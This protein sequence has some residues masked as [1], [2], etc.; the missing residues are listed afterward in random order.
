MAGAKGNETLSNY[1]KDF[2]SVL[3]GY[4]ERI[5]RETAMIKGLAPGE[6]IAQRDNMLLE[7]GED[8]AE[9]LVSLIVC[10]NAQ[11]IVELGTSYGYSTLFLAHAARITGGRVFTYEMSAEKQDYARKQLST[12]KLDQFVEWKLGD[13]V[14]LLDTQPGP[15]DFSFIDL[16]KDLYVPCFEKLYPNLA[17]NGIVVA[18]NMLH[19]PPARED[20][21][22]YQRA[23]RSK[24][25]MEAV[26]LHMGNGL[27][28]S[29]RRGTQ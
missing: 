14:E 7:V 1:S 13:A 9:L 12:A 6:M 23:V 20:A 8:A 24:P 19:P 2:E 17:T 26:L 18:D 28:I 15:I 16:W 29:T 25:E 27:D 10:A 11:V 21:V 5:A 4:R 3:T 22:R